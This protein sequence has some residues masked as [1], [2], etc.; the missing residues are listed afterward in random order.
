MASTVVVLRFIDIYDK[1]YICHAG[2]YQNAFRSNLNGFEDR[3]DAVKFA[4]RNSCQVVHYLH[5]QL[6]EY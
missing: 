4:E 1:W 5:D 6:Q 2:S 3:Q